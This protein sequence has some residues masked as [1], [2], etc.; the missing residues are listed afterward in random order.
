MVMGKQII[1]RGISCC[2]AHPARCAP[3]ADFRCKEQF[4]DILGTHNKRAAM[5]TRPEHTSRWALQEAAIK[6]EIDEA[7]NTV[8]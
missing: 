2:G 6:A 5:I 4:C 7:K 8:I 3:I 1:G